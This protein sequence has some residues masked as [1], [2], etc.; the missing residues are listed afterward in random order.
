MYLKQADLFW[1]MDKEFVKEAM[2]ITT[3]ESLEEGQTYLRRGIQPNR[4]TFLSKA[5]LNL[6]WAR[7]RE[8]FTSPI[9]LERL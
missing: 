3:K 7:N 8:K 2:I 6:P 1:G 9:S 5:G 4:F